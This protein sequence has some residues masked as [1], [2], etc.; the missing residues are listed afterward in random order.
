MEPLPIIFNF[1]NSTGESGLGKTTFVNTLFTTGIKDQKNFNRRKVKQ[2]AKTV[3]V[4]IT[5]A[6]KILSRLKN[7]GDRKEGV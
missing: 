5:K 3:Q 2:T 7:A 4:Q 1:W 6:G